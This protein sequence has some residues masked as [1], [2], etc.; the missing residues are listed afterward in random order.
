[1][2]N[3]WRKTVALFWKRPVLWL[4]LLCANL[5][6]FCLARVQGLITR[7]FIHWYLA[8]NS[9]LL[10]AFDHF[11]VLK[12][13]L[14][15][16]PL[17]WG[18]Y[19]L[20]IG[21]YATALVVTASLVR[22]LPSAFSEFRP[23][24]GDIVV[25][26]LMLF[27]L[28]VIATLLVGALS[29]GLVVRQTGLLAKSPF[30]LGLAALVSMGI[31]YLITPAALTLLGTAQSQPISAGSLRWGRS[32]SILAVAAS[33]AI[34]FFAE[35]GERS[36]VTT[37]PITRGNLLIAVG[38]LTSLLAAIPYIPLFISLSLIADGEV[39]HPEISHADA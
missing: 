21:F 31:A 39:P 10:P 13:A 12:I 11:L 25:F 24:L 17:V 18:T 6:G 37:A 4:P 27:A 35:T 20:N 19:L 29:V 16:G 28:W 30:V 1:M 5:A 33:S 36:L 8:R 38:A 32:F 14:M 34:A 23:R 15:T 3:L 9:S 2:K 7:Q 22:R 26:S